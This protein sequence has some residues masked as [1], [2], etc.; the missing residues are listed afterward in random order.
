[1]LNEIFSE[2]YVFLVDLNFKKKQ[3]FIEVFKFCDFFIYLFFLH[4]LIRILKD[5]P[6]MLGK[7]EPIHVNTERI[8]IFFNFLKIKFDDQIFFSCFKSILI[9]KIVRNKYKIFYTCN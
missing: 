8:Q 1:M 5:D 9:M 7:T 2:Q 3:K 6:S 4:N